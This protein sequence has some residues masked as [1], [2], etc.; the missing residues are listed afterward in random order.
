MG[1][2]FERIQEIL[3][4]VSKAVIHNCLCGWVCA[5]FSGVF[6]LKPIFNAYKYRLF[7]IISSSL[8][9]SHS[10]SSCYA[11]IS[12][13]LSLHA[14]NAHTHNFRNVTQHETQFGVIIVVGFYFILFSFSYRLI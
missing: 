12:E 8:S 3:C 10:H 1:R 11:W 7:A 4:I 5:F 14:K 6:A 13:L 2:F 9:P